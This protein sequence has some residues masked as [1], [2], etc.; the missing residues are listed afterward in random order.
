MSTCHYLVVLVKR[1]ERQECAVFEFVAERERR[2]D[3][4]RNASSWAKQVFKDRHDLGSCN[5]L[6][7]VDGS[8]V[9]L[10]DGKSPK[11]QLHSSYRGPFIISGKDD[12]H[13]KLYTLK[14]IN[15]TPIPGTFYGD[16]LEPFV[17]RIGN[18]VTGNEEELALHQNIRAKRGFHKLPQRLRVDHI[19]VDGI[20]RNFD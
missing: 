19:T 10:Y 11:K 4:V 2:W 16:H 15:G 9:I 6:N 5:E 1:K 3:E 18:L 13:G 17:P 14:Q 7:F 20:E 8:M 12:S